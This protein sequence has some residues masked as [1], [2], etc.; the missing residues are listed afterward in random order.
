MSTQTEKMIYCFSREPGGAEALS[1]VLKGRDA[2]LY[3]LI[4]KDY[5]C[6]IFDSHGLAYMRYQGNTREE[7]FVFIDN[8]HE[9][10]PVSIVLTSAGSIPEHDM[11]EKY[12][13]NWASSRGVPSIAVLDQWQNYKERFSGPN[14]THSLKYLPD[15]ICVMD[16]SARRG[17][18]DDGLPGER[19]EIVGHPSL[20]KLRNIMTALGVS[21]NEDIR[22][23]LKVGSD[24]QLVLFVAEPFT[25]F[26]G[27]RAGYTEL[28]ILEELIFYFQERFLSLKKGYNDIGLVIKLH[29]KNNLE[30]FKKFRE[31]HVE[32]WETL[33]PVV[34]TG[35]VDKIA[36]LTASDLVVGMASIMLMEA[37][38]LGKPTV[39]IQVGAMISHLCEAVNQGIIPFISTRS[40]MNLVLDRLLDDRS[41]KEKYIENIKNYPIID[42]ADSRIWETVES[43]K[44]R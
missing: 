13:W 40:E 32:I 37:I 12:L 17:M 16:E 24:Q 18:I 21:G 31:K 20:S 29:P 9:Q 39:S 11:T 30:V 36:L 5:A 4:G 44:L 10:K 38:A 43:R 42:N 15:V 22:K 8:L 23:K 33:D 2:H 26:Y 14:G 1:L 35:E 28:T 25:H 34:L 3:C 41:Y 7:L 19:I 27:D 6:D